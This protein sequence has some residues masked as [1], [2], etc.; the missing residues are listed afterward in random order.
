MKN[1]LYIITNESIYYKD[2]N[3]YCDNIDLKSIPE[4]FN[5][6]T[7]VFVIGRKSKTPRSKKID[8]EN[9]KVSSNIFFYLYFVFRSFLKKK[10]HI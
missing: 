2:G 6:E 5:K 4:S 1:N 9:I 10:K 7:N 8:I 3:Y